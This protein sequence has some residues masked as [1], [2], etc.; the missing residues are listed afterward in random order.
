VSSLDRWVLVF[1]FLM[2]AA[3]AYVACEAPCASLG[4]VPV[5][6]LPARCL[7]GAGGDR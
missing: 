4:W 5:K 7:P 6:D 3:S 1:V 2:L